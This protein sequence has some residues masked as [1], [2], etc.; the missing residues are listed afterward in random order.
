MEMRLSLG[1]MSSTRLQRAFTVL[2][3][4]LVPLAGAGA[5]EGAALGQEDDAK[6]DDPPSP[7]ASQDAIDTAIDRGVTYLLGRQCLDGSWKPDEERYVSGQTGL[8][9]YTL[10]KAGLPRDHPS[11]VRGI[12]FIR[13]HPPRWTYGISCCVLALQTANGARYK[14][15]ISAWTERLL[16]GHGKG[17]SYPGSHEDLSLTQY[18]CLALR[19]AES[20]GFEVSK[21]IW[22]DLVDFAFRVYKDDGS[23]TYTPGNKSTGSMTSAGV[24]VLQIARDALEAKGK[25]SRREEKRIDEA[26]ENGLKWLGE[27]FAVDRNPD[28]I[29]K[30]QSAGHMT[31]W[32]LYFLY[33]LERVGGL[34]GRPKFGE[35]DWYA[36]ASTFLVNAQGALGAWGTPYGEKHPGT[37]FGVLV[38]KRATAPSSGGKASAHARAYGDDDPAREVSLRV[39]GDTPMTAWVSTIGDAAKTKHEWSLERGKGPRVH[40]VEYINPESGEVYA[41]IKGNP[42][43]AS[44]GKRFAAQLRMKKP[45]TYKVAARVFVRPLDASA[46]EEVAL[47][48]QTLDIRVDGVM[49]QGMRAA[50]ADFGRNEL[51]KVKCDVKASSSHAR[52][53]AR[54]VNDG[55]T[56]Y[57]WLCSHEDEAPWIAIEPTRPQRGDH[58]VLTPHVASA[59]ELGAWGQPTKILLRINGKKAGEHLIVVDEYAKTYIPLKKKLTIRS[60][61]IE[62]LERRQGTSGGDGK[63]VGFAEVA[64]Q[65]RPD[66]RRSKR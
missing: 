25:L 12:A 42:E 31:R 4:A 8:C 57:G 43:E 54:F 6:A 35:H 47:Q 46:S 41:T 28:P 20:V 52:H 17:F 27:N 61:K 60:I 24:A 58:V 48:S 14:E 30:N 5:S 66:L 50:M 21:D 2:L 9:L 16:E 34:T 1:P 23:F 51:S 63:L 3:V 40:R 29:E 39:T 36:K 44:K 55:L 53:P 38:L 7:F 11:I 64:L 33:G 65:L 45:G 22:E 62:V 37:C 18:G 56:C 59:T 19:A 49:T 15:E 32:K 10:L 26:I 13:A